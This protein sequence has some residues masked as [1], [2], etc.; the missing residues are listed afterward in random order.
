MI[1]GTDV[2][3]FMTNR[4]GY[5]CGHQWRPVSEDLVPQEIKLEVYSSPEYKAWAAA[6]GK[7]PVEVPQKQQ[8][9]KVKENPPVIPA[10]TS[11]GEKLKTKIIQQNDQELQTLKKKDFQLHEDLLAHLGE[12]ISFQKGLPNEAYYSPIGKKIVVGNMGDRM[13]SKYFKETLLAHELGH[14]IHNTKGIINLGKVSPEFEQHFDGLK[15]II[16]GKEQDIQDKFWDAYKTSSN[17]TKEHLMVV[18]D[19]L[20]SLT[21]GRFG[22]GHPKSY[23]KIAGKSEA[24]IFA[25]SVSLL[26]VKNNFEEITP[27]MKQVIEEMKKF[28]SN[29]L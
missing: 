21:K 1:P 18:F 3:N 28:V 12:Q 24:E 17:D 23:Y 10:A 26:K 20:G 15:K 22:G 16:K 19:I 4:G 6:H 14:A 8:Q 7:T 11:T 25:H 13:G 5:N 2:S 29:I 27:E 9:K